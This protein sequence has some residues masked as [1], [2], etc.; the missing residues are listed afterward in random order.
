MLSGPTLGT[1]SCV[2]LRLRLPGNLAFFE[3]NANACRQPCLQ[4]DDDLAC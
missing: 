1:L 2:P 3:L 4:S